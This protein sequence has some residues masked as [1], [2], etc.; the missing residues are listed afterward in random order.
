MQ[1]ARHRG[2]ALPA[3]GRADALA[4]RRAVVGTGRR[5]D[6]E[7]ALVPVDQH[8][9]AAIQLHLLGAVGGVFWKMGTRWLC[10]N[11]YAKSPLT[12]SFPMK[13]WDFP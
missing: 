6:V 12:V 3:P 7:L 1:R 2:R 10:Q 5:G 4:Q 13:N 11:N 9:R 8:G